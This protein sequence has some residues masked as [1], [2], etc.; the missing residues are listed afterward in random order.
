M[1][2]RRVVVFDLDGTVRASSHLA[3]VA[4]NARSSAVMSLTLPGIGRVG[5]TAR[6]AVRLARTERADQGP[7]T[8]TVNRTASDQPHDAPRYPERPVREDHGE[9]PG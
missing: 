6:R 2:R 9:Q 8:S 5:S 4:G 1:S 7:V 3:E